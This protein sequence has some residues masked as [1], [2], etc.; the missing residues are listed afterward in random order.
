MN[1]IHKLS[2]FKKGNYK[3]IAM[4]CKPSKTGKNIEAKSIN[5][6]HVNCPRCLAFKENE[7]LITDQRNL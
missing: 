6:S 1:K 3:Q 2:W 7:K 5:W 4:L